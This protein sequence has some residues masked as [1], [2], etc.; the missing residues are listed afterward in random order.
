MRNAWMSSAPGNL[1]ARILIIVQRKYLDFRLKGLF[2]KFGALLFSASYS[3]PRWMIE[4]REKIVMSFTALIPLLRLFLVCLA[5]TDAPLLA[6]ERETR[7]ES[8]YYS[9]LSYNAFQDKLITVL[10]ARPCEKRR[11]TDIPVFVEGR[12]EYGLDPLEALALLGKSPY[13]ERLW[14]A[15]QEAS[16]AH[17]VV[18]KNGIHFK[19]D[20]MEDLDPAM[21]SAIYLF[22]QTVFGR[23]VTP[24]CL[25]TFRG[26]PVKIPPEKQPNEPQILQDYRCKKSEYEHEGAGHK[27]TQWVLDH[28][29]ILPHLEDRTLNF[30]VQAS[31]TVQG[32]LLTNFMEK[33]KTGAQQWENIDAQTAQEFLL[34]SLLTIAEDLNP[35]NVMLGE[36]AENRFVVIG[37]DNDRSFAFP[38]VKT[39]P[40]H[41]HTPTSHIIQAKN[42]LLATLYLLDQTLHPDVASKCLAPC[43]ELIARWFKGLYEREK[44]YNA[45]IES[46][47]FFSSTDG[48]P[49]YTKLGIP[50]KFVPGT[51]TRLYERMHAL[52]DYLQNYLKGHGQQ[53][54][55]GEVFFHMYPL[56]AA[57]YQKLCKQYPCPL[58]CTEALY[59]PASRYV[60]LPPHMRLR[61]GQ[62]VEEALRYFQNSPDDFILKRE[63]RLGTACSFFLDDMAMAYLGL[64]SLNAGTNKQ[65]EDFL[66][67]LSVISQSNIDLTKIQTGRWGD[68][69]IL[70]MLG[71]HNA[72]LKCI[73]LAAALRAS[74]PG[75]GMRLEK[76]DSSSYAIS[77]TGGKIA[78]LCD[79]IA[80]FPE[81]TALS[82]DN[83]QLTS[84]KP[85]MPTLRHLSHLTSL[86]LNNNPIDDPSSLLHLTQLKSL[87]KLF[88]AE[89]KLVNLDALPR[90]PALKDLD[91]TNNGITSLK[92]LL[93][94]QN[95]TKFPQLLTLIL[96]KNQLTSDDSLKLIL[97]SNYLTLLDLS[98]NFL[99]EVPALRNLRWLNYIDLR[100]NV[101]PDHQLG[102]ED[103]RISYRPQRS[104]QSR[105]ERTQKRFGWF[106]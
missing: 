52:Q 43:E 51:V 45:M 56:L 79:L 66:R 25:L 90:M 40:S 30:A 53:P 48:H 5:F 82:L 102:Q 47:A 15:A 54:T 70:K 64:D 63:E 39:P 6:G 34:G 36:V 104:N 91:L 67:A 41:T 32:I 31:Q 80:L 14:L 17:R 61:N 71:R 81:M 49:I 2:Y 38:I 33:V 57:Q 19:I 11:E 18:H 73:Q 29:D 100:E 37:I 26:L 92:G 68:P 87:T 83:N 72:P 69:E 84:L 28:P 22:Y 65:E 13:E 93:T 27:L 89:V 62:T 9:P 105:S 44:S 46:G 95:H 50:L 3:M 103:S 16:G 55:L 77:G 35:N 1:Y 74:L 88:L 7:Q 21:E 98:A 12:G 86:S 75:A 78:I 101:I 4:L 23:G 76:S 60:N 58:A 10:N 20:T 106:F 97:N 59:N 85:L 99:T 42:C 24:S 8:P 96:A 94:K